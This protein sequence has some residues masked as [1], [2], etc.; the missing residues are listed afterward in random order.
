M[1][2]PN[3]GKENEAQ[4]DICPVCGA[5]LRQQT[6]QNAPDVATAPPTPPPVAAPAAPPPASVPSTETPIQ[7]A[8]QQPAKGD[9][10]V[11]GY[12]VAG[13][14]DRLIAIIL[15]SVM[16]MAAFAA[17]GMWIASLMGG[18][19]TGGFSMQG[20][21]AFITI[22]LTMFLGFVYFWFMEGIAG[23]TLGKRIMGLQIRGINGDRCTLT[24]SLVRNLLRII[25]G[26]GVYLVGF[27]I[28]LFSK[29][30]QRLGDHLAKTV[31]VEAAP[32]TALRIVF[33]FLWLAIIAGGIWGA[34]IIHS[35]I[36]A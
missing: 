19:T 22:G 8:P 30:R 14:G 6:F 26:L 9:R 1:F 21:P 25:D 10:L 11:A 17:I 20:P 31:V 4:V 33:V 18:R 27:F 24:Q 7:P 16:M 28:A 2:C 3:C 36:P 5:P 23:G 35:R 32:S 13:L 12:R 15:D 34:Y 29:F